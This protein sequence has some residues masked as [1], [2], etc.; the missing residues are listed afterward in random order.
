M[1]YIRWQEPTK[2]PTLEASHCHATV[3]RS[4]RLRCVS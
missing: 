4:V 3:L 2:M 1:M